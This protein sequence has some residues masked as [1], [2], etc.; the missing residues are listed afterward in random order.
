MRVLLCF[1]VLCR[2]LG[3]FGLVSGMHCRAVHVEDELDGSVCAD[4]VQVLLG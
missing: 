3:G 1:I 4:V 2:K